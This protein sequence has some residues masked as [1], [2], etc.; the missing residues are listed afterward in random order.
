M[1]SFFFLFLL[2]LTISFAACGGSEDEMPP[3][4]EVVGTWEAIFFEAETETSTDFNGMMTNTTAQ[5][6][7]SNLNYEATF[8]AT[9]FTTMG[10]Y[11][12]TTTTTVPPNPPFVSMSSLTDIEGSGS[13]SIDGNQMTISGSFFAIEINGSPVD[14]GGEEQVVTYEINADGEL[15]FTQDQEFVTTQPGV[16]TTS[17][18]RST[19]IWRRI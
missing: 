8:N 6:T 17:V 10:D 13:Y 4:N 2:S 1:R 3:A 15:V 14:T 18:I 19:S 16:T 5:I 12:L 7:S 11:D 9:T